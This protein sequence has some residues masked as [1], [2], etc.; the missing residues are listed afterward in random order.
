MNYIKQKSC[1][2]LSPYR[3][4]FL[5]ISKNSKSLN[6]PKIE[7]N[8]LLKDYVTKSRNPFYFYLRQSK[9]LKNEEKSEKITDY[10]FL[11]TRAER[12]K[13]LKLKEKVQKIEKEKLREY[14]QKNKKFIKYKNMLPIS[15]WNKCEKT[16]EEYK[17]KNKKLINLKMAN[18]KEIIINFDEDKNAKSDRI[19]NKNINSRNIKYKNK[20]YIKNNFDNIYLDKTNNFTRCINKINIQ[21]KFVNNGLNKFIEN[22]EN[23]SYINI[24]HF[25]LNNSIFNK[26]YKFNKK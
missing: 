19:I 1:F 7:H 9:P 17:K 26:K 22:I 14:A 11:L 3:N 8:S 6:L 24:H 21:Q 25:K 13:L 23:R 20:R 4:K 2:G 10:T 15:I 16:Y 5:N 12:E 18:N